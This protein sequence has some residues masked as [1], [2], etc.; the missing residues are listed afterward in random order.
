LVVRIAENSSVV[1]STIRR[2]AHLPTSALFWFW[3]RFVDQCDTFT[4][5]EIYAQSPV[6]LHTTSTDLETLELIFDT[7]AILRATTPALVCG[8]SA[9]Q[10]G[11]D[12]FTA[13]MATVNSTQRLTQLREL[14]KN[15]KVDVYS[16]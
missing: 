11:T 3:R 7:T 5:S 14:M 1:T 12:R 9:M 2:L 13:D 10:T 15:H 8:T 6:P 16:M 4:H